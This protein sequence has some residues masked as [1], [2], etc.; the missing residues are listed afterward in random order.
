MI[1]VFTARVPEYL[2]NKAD[3]EATVKFSHLIPDCCN[4]STGNHTK[5]DISI[6]S[7]NK[8]ISVLSLL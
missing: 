8:D 2:C 7:K 5:Y 6:F 1:K 4:Y 3:F